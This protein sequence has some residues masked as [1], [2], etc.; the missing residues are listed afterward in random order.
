MDTIFISSEKSKTS[1]PQR[2]L[3]NLSFNIKL[4]R[5]DEYVAVSNLST[6]YI[7]KK[8]RYK[9]NE[10]K[11]SAPTWNAEF[12]LP[13]GSYSLADIQDYFEYIIKKWDGFWYSFI[14]DISK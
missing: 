2:L 14:K 11:I 7:W 1:D 13:D 4:K 10:S 6:Y 3:L 12:E 8:Y 5:S 9:N